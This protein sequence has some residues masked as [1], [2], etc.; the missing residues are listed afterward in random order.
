MEGLRRNAK[1]IA[2]NQKRNFEVE[3]SRFEHCKPRREA[4]LNGY[5]VQVYSPE[6]MVCEKIRAICQQMKEYRA[7]VKSQAA[8]ARARDF[9][10]IYNLMEKFKIVLATKE[11]T[12]LLR[13]VFRV[14]RVPFELLGKIESFRDFHRSDFQRVKDTVDPTIDLLDFDFYF[15]YLLDEVKK[16]EPLWIE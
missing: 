2:P 11:N 14:K 10:D 13:N 15:D 3:I 16:L 8:S 4:D 9:F 6:L 7:I 12:E 5:A 1:P